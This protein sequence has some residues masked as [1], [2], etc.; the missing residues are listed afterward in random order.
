[1]RTTT[2]P[3]GFDPAALARRAAA[4]SRGADATLLG[5]YIETLAAAAGDSRRLVQPELDRSRVG[6]ITAAEAGVP[7]GAVV[8]LYLSAT[9][10][11]WRHLPRPPNTDTNDVAMAVLRAANDAIVALVEGY[12]SAQRT[13]IRHEEAIR[14]EFIDDLLHGTGDTTELAVR[15]ARFGLQLAGV[16]AVAVACTDVAFTDGDERTRRIEAALLT[17]C[18]P[19]DL[20]IVTKESQLVC[21]APGNQPA[22]CGAFADQAIALLSDENCRIGIGRSH[23][24]P[25]GVAHSYREA[26]DVLDLAGRIGLSTPVLQAKDLLV[27]QVLI[28]DHAAIADLVTTVLEPLQRHRGGP[29]PL[30][31]TLAAYFDAGNATAA[32]RR[33]H[34]GVRTV[35]Y[36]LRRVREL[37]GYDAGEPSQR[38]TLQTAVLGARLL[39]WPHQTARGADREA[40]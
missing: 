11:A 32:A 18:G 35:A 27:F 17:R 5:D 26:R 23:A 1:M 40:T 4:D 38:F 30:I 3:R 6:G 34:I 22:A 15:A 31:D 39:D 33:L 12:E 10:V 20:L 28:R 36:R 16:H 2:R 19:G 14:R 8:D 9:W 25:A 21:V 37:T 24:G 13:A 29:R 7:L